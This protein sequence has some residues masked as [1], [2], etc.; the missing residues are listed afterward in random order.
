MSEVSNTPTL[1]EAVGKKYS[2][3]GYQPG[4]I[5]L[6]GF[7]E[8]DFTTISLEKADQVAQ[9]FPKLLVPVEKSIPAATRPAAGS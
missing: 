3:K 7:G 1:P 4:P 5:I 6:K 8:V 9:K 2:L